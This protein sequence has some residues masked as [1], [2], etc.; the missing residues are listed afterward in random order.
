M[1][2]LAGFV[3]RRNMMSES[4]DVIDDPVLAAASFLFSFNEWMTESRVFAKQFRNGSVKDQR[5]E[6][7]FPD[8]FVD[9][10]SW[11]IFFDWD[12]SGKIEHN[13]VGGVVLDSLIDF[14][15]PNYNGVRVG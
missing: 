11:G 6:L 14:V 10:Q 3:E 4:P 2:F 15:E 7:L 5:A 1:N 8:M 9:L 12:T 13:Y